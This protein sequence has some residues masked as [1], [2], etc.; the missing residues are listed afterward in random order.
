[1]DEKS[2]PGLTMKSKLRLEG[3]HC[4]SCNALVEKQLMTVPGLISAK[5]DFRRG[6][7][8]V[9][10]RGDLD[11][12]ALQRAVEEQGYRIVL[13]GDGRK[14]S[15]GKSKRYAEVAGAFLIVVAI[16]TMLNRLDL[17]PNGLAVG[18]NMGYG[19]IFLI[20]LVASVSSCM[21]VTGG[22]LVAIAAKYNAASPG[23]PGKDR[24]RTH[25]AFNAGRIVSY[26]LLG[27]A[28]GALGRVLMPSPEAAVLLT[29]I[30]PAIMILLGLQM[31]GLFPALRLLIPALPQVVTNRIN[32]LA[33]RQSRGGA[34]ALG[35]LTFFLPCGFTQALQLYVL[36]K[37]ALRGRRANNAGLLARDLTCIAVARRLGIR[38][39]LSAEETTVITF[40]P[41]KVGQFK[42]NCAMGMM[43]PDSKFTVVPNV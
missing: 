30:A 37:G 41:D 19:V 3:M 16:A 31:V 22:L 24:W 32:D 36:T 43:T 15:S 8:E 9:T 33:V 18:D 40:H 17:M 4:S 21:A 2:N 38:H 6:K 35:A 11:R 29:I 27:G 25:L 39:L 28:I 5:A 1:M 26:T 42:F 12:E 14:D 34:F 10:H 20:G 13:S 7:A 23:L